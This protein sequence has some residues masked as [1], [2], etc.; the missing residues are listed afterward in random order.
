MRALTKREVVAMWLFH[1]QYVAQ[2]QGAIE[3][4]RNLSQSNKELIDDMLKEIK[5]ASHD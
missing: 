3:F 4:Y 5:E 1:E 2:S